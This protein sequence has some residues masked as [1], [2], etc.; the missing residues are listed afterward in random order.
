MSNEEQSQQAP[1]LPQHGLYKHRPMNKT[2]FNNNYIK[3]ERGKIMIFIDGSNLF[4]TSQM[5]GIEIDYI[6]LVEALVGKDKLVRVYFYAGID[7][8]NTLS[9]NWQYFMK[10]TG[11]KMVTKEL[12]T[13]ANGNR[14]ANCDVEMAVDMV[15][16][17]HAFD[18]AIVITGDG[19][20]ARAC[21]Y[22]SQQGK[23]VELIGNKF[24]T[25]EKLIAVADRFI[26]LETLR[27]IITKN[28]RNQS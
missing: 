15:T 20:L 4:Y 14:K 9:F 16:L 10:R 23:Q 7:S 17:T 8:E 18:T 26:D 21:E 11:F 13:F 6:K 22:L 28:I 25:N 5:M 3:T 27:N 19:D 12:Q 1:P 2:H 24:N